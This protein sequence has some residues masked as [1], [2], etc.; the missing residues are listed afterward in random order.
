MK[1]SFLFIAALVLSMAAK[2]W[3]VGDF[4]VDEQ[5]GVPAL[6]AYV[7]KTGEHGLIM[8]PRAYSEEGFQKSLKTFEANKKWAQKDIAKRYKAV[9]KSKN[10]EQIAAMEKQM[11]QQNAHYALLLDY[12][13]HAPRISSSPWK[14]KEERA[15]I[16]KLSAQNNEYGEQN[17]ANALA[18]CQENNIDR[19][20]YFPQY[21]YAVSLGEGWF[22][23]G[24]HELE[25]FSKFFVD[26]MG[27]AHRISAK[28]KLAMDKA[29]REKLGPMGDWLAYN[30]FYATTLIRSSTMLL[31][32]W[33]SD[34]ANKSK[35]TV[36]LK[37]S[38]WD[39]EDNYFTFCAYVNVFYW[40]IF[41]KN[42]QSSSYIVAFKRF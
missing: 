28:E 38:N 11:E 6:V 5:T 42:L 33:T 37:N 1:K 27:E 32:A 21:E 18:Y 8:S 24:N 39:L 40:W 12:L 2:A 3:E 29:L 34:P 20:T 7:D 15:M 17:Q 26:E 30:C 13:A 23:P 10:A 4:Y 41:V 31:S 14:E 25:L 16:S 36:Q 19:A 9:K 22:A 35:M